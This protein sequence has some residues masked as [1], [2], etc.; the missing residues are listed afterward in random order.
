MTN[1]SPPRRLN[2]VDMS[3]WGGPLSDDEARQLWEAGVRNIK[4]GDGSTQGAGAFARQ[5]AEAWLRLQ[6]ES[7]GSV[8]AYI[9]LYMAGDPAEQVATA[10]Q[11]LAGLPI[12]HWWLDAEDVESPALTPAQREAFLCACLDALDD[13]TP[14]AEARRA[15]GIYTG[16]WWWVPNMANSTLFADLPLWNSWYDN[17]PDE[18]GLPYGGWQHSAV[19]QYAGT[20]MLGGVSVDLDFDTTLDQVEGQEPGQ[21]PNTQEELTMEDKARLDRLERIVAGWGFSSDEGAP[22]SGD[23]AIAFIDEHQRSMY[24]GLLNTQTDL[25]KHVADWNGHHPISTSTSSSRPTLTP[26]GEGIRAAELTK[27]GDAATGS[28]R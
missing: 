26:T 16:R 3:R 17:D 9:Y 22:L 20:T 1:E 24:Q 2:C 27:E 10:I 11:T 25:A 21:D 13:R 7:G 14:A 23:D 8:D 4:V 5:Q 6:G 18:S 12:R 19:E 28:T 15:A